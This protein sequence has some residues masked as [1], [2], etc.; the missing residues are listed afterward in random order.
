MENRTYRYF[1]GNALYPFGFGL[2]YTHF[3]FQWMNKPAKQYA[4]NDLI[5]C[6]IKVKNSGKLKGGEVVQAY[7]GYPQEDFKL[8]LKE[9]RQFNRI[10]LSEGKSENITINIPVKDL[11][12]WSE[13]ELK[14]TLYKGNYQLFIGSNS[15]DAQ[16]VANF[17]I[18]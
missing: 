8:P 6:T 10:A 4:I 13:K 15:S 11:Q 18:K 7:I 5:S 16:L 1:G 2:S 9:L 12:K 3:D 17:D 14:Q